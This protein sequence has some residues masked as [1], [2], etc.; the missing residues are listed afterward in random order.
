MKWIVMLLVFVGGIYYLVN[1]HKT[2]LHQ[3]EVIEQTKKERA[4][5]IEE[6][7]LPPA[8]ETTYTMKFSLN[9]LKTLR[10]LTQDPNEKVRFAAVE[11]LWQLQDEQIPGVIK[12]MFANETEASVKKSIIDMLSKDKSRLSLALITGAMSDYDKETRLK[13]VEAIGTFSNKEAITALNPAMEDYDEEIRLKA[14]EAVNHIRQDI[15]TNKEQKM[16]ELEMKPIFKI[17]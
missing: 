6:Q 2:E 4:Q 3:Q 9:T 1:R 11:L 8:P 5:A 14:I 16:R 10:N 12:W 15:Q 17:E 7:T 13:A